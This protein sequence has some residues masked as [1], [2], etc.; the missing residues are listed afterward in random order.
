MKCIGTLIP[1]GW[2]HV[3]FFCALG[4]FFGV[5]LEIIKITISE[6]YQNLLHEALGLKILDIMLFLKL[7]LN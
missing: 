2:Y 6:L 1:T 7:S 4:V 5:N 3:K